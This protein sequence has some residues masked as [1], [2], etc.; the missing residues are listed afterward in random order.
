MEYKSVFEA[1]S[2]NY[3]IEK[4]RFIAHVRPVKTETQANAFIESVK[5]E[6]WNA[7]HNVP[8]YLIGEHAEIQKFN[9]DGEPS[10]TAAYP[11]LDMLKKEGITDI[12]IVITRYFGGIK[13][14]KGGLVRAYTHSA[15]LGL[16]Q[17]RIVTFKECT[18]YCLT[19]EYPLHGKVENHLHQQNALIRTDT[20]YGAVVE[21]DILVPTG[22]VVLLDPLIELSGNQIQMKERDTAYHCIEDGQILGG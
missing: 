10:G 15:K 2:T 9:D 17:S 4:S 1:S 3:T 12:V 14:G 6:Y 22:E 21:M 8:V 13:L 19:Y 7:S 11:I 16:E 5:K 18:R 20:R